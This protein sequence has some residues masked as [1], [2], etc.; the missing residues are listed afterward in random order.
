ML[1]CLPL[2][3]SAHPVPDLERTGSITVTM[4]YKKKPV[5]GGK[6][7]L[8]RVGDV[9]EDDGNYSFVPAEGITG[10]T[11]DNVQSADLAAKLAKYVSTKKISAIKTVTVSSKGTAVFKDLTPGLYLVVQKTAA[12]GY[13]K[14]SPFLV[15]LPYLD[16]EEYV[17][18]VKADPKTEL[19]PTVKPT[20]APPTEAPSSDTPSGNRLA[21]TGQ[22]WW[23]VPLLICAGLACIVLGLLR[24]RKNS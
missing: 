12:S 20:G 1:V 10:F 19:E 22:L 9:H 4:T 21:Q 3:V 24:R 16:G 15:S 5:S 6:L 13:G 14:A 8:Y 11:F 2:S 7:A 17:Y 23:P 18:D